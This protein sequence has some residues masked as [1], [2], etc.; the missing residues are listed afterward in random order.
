M[1]CARV[2]FFTIC[3]VALLKGTVT[4]AEQAP[5]QTPAIAPTP[6]AIS[7]E[8]EFSK[9]AFARAGEVSGKIHLSKALSAE[10]KVTLTWKDCFGRTAAVHEESAE[11][12]EKDLSFEFPAAP[13]VGIANTLSAEIE[14][15]SGGAKTTASKE[16]IVTPDYEPWDDYQIIM[17]YAYKPEFQKRLRELGITAGMNQGTSR[18]LD[19]S[20]DKTRIWWGYGFRFYAEQILTPIYAEYHRNIEDKPKN[21]R[22]TEAKELYKKDKTSKAAFIRKPCFSDPD[23]R[24]KIEETMQHV[25]ETNAK[26]APLFYSLA[27]EAGVADL[28]SAWDFCYDPRTLAA[29]RDWLKTQYTT[30]EGLNK[31]W[32]TAFT[33]WD[34]VT[35]LTTDEMMKRGDDNLSPWADHR[36][37]M[38]AVFAD[39]VKW[40]VDATLKADPHAYCGLV[41]CQMPSAFGG[42]D[43]WR[44]SQTMNVI[45][46]YNIGNN[47]DIWRSFR[48][49]AP[50][51]TTSFG[52]SE[53]EK[54]RLWHQ[55]INGDR[56]III[57]DEK[58]SYL[59]DKGEATDVGRQSA[60]V[61]HELTGGICKLLSNSTQV[62]DPIAI[63]YSQA[64]IHAHWML[65]ARPDGEAWIE[66]GSAAERLKSDFLRLRESFTKLIE[67]QQLQY[68]FV[69]YAQ[70]EQGELAKNPPKLL[71]LPQSIAMSPAECAAVRAYVEAGG[72]L[73]ADIRCAL[74]D[75]HC[76][77]LEKG[78]LDDLFGI[79][80]T[81]QD[82]KPG[83]KLVKPADGARPQ[84]FISRELKLSAAEPGV[85]VDA[86]RGAT[87]L[88]TNGTSVPAVIVRSV[89]KGRAVYLNLDLTDYHRW[90]LKPGEETDARELF[91]S[92]Y[93]LANVQPTITATKA[94]GGYIP[95]VEI[96]TYQNGPVKIVAIQRNF[97]LRI[98]ELGPM[99]YQSNEAFE[100]DEKVDIN[101]GAPYSV[102]D[103]R[104]G[105]AL[106]EIQ[107]L[108]VELKAYEPLIFTLLPKPAKEFTI[109]AT[110]NA[111]RGE[112][113]AIAASLEAPTPAEVHV[114]HLEI[115]GP[116]GKTIPYY[117]RNL[118][119]PLGV[120]VTRLY[121]ALSDPPG[122]YTITLRDVATG[123]TGKKT[124]QVE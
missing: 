9:R 82:W 88:F 19:A 91:A 42:Y 62:N 52:Y 120:A 96:R 115:A 31:E 63:H 79:T 68:T 92:L 37:F 18:L 112:Q 75:E 81:N 45:E 78:Q 90:R 6:S 34:D 14:D 10:S 105:S 59:N 27:D 70:L 118:K 100:K 43:Y 32:G 49:E 55:L 73:V 84:N 21:I 101:F 54:W 33:K 117:T 57:Y 87:A 89:G 95:G 98:N 17:Y 80:R 121:L 109:L 29:M 15:G 25:V 40:G 51:L 3:L 39:A 108:R 76:K 122:N 22:L 26:L 85:Q 113:I 23:V 93:K 66:R 58:N 35:P 97:Q 74:M 103:T 8:L 71:F 24:K 47:R 56:G 119:A 2:H 83:E 41:G 7:A 48:P 28:P 61:Y 16:F 1:P 107:S 5:A 36:T 111:K 4:M 67:D 12:G 20:N 99:E 77:R 60:G 38:E 104:A 114:F 64:S 94:E 86:A 123:I 72:T 124:L 50:A 30:V 53:Q 102:Y 44:L 65:Q 116:D 46:P 106:G 69:A 11:A 13:S 110:N